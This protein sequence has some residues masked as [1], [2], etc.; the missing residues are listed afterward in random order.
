MTQ[1]IAKPRKKRSDKG[2]PCPQRGNRY[3]PQD[4][5]A[6]H[7]FYSQ[8]SPQKISEDLQIPIITIQKII[9]YMQNYELNKII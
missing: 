6:I 2:K 9:A 7:E 4:K 1:K 3:N 5:H 8:F